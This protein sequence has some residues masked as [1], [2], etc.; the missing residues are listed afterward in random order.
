[1]FLNFTLSP[2]NLEQSS[3][4]A[5]AALGALYTRPV[6]PKSQIILNANIDHRVN[7]STHFVDASNL[8]LGAGWSLQRGVNSFSVSANRVYSWLDRSENKHDTG[9]NFS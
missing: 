1:V 5:N 7:P 9:I 2:N 4:F 3:S 6:G 8:N